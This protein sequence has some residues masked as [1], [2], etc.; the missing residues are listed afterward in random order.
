MLKDLI[1]TIDY[2]LLENDIGYKIASAVDWLTVTTA[3]DRIGAS[4]TEKYMHY[5]DTLP[6]D[7]PHLVQ[8]PWKSLGY[9][10]VGVP[11]IRLGK[12]KNVGYIVILSGGV[13]D[14]LWQFFLP[15]ARRVTRIDLAV[16]V[17]FGLALPR[18]A[19]LYYDHVT[20]AEKQD[21]GRK[22]TLIT[23]NKGGQTFYVG[24]RSSQQFARVYDKGIE[25]K[26]A[27]QGFCWRYEVEYKKPLA[28]QIAR[29][30]DN[31][32]EQNSKAIIGTIY[33]W[34]QS[35]GVPP[36]FRETAEGVNASVEARVTSDDRKINWLH[37]QVRPTVE[38][39]IARGRNIEVLFALGLISESEF[40]KIVSE[41]Q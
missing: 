35:R 36:L 10:G 5:R 20:E 40:K 15:G 25:A 16:T 24:S 33:R 18:L 22:Y 21:K 3:D 13:S 12:A 39:L 14:Q 32:G 26:V 8:K 38:Y 28:S 17:N 37:S 29:A 27:P 41:A 6:G 34:F 2:D 23:N 4:W 7:N 1:K 19:S 30:L 9:D 31:V 11:G